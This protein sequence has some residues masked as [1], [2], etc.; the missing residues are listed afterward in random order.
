M[1]KTADLQLSGSKLEKRM[2]RK[3]SPCLSAALTWTPGR[4][5]RRR[6]RDTAPAWSSRAHWPP[7]SGPS[8]PS[9]ARRWAWPRR[10]SLCWGLLPPCPGCFPRAPPAAARESYIFS[11]Q[12]KK[13]SCSRT[14]TTPNPHRGKFKRQKKFVGAEGRDYSDLPR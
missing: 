11:A 13:K 12:K 8:S 6:R 2:N 14:S 4:K 1:L 10:C 9:P 5:L 7:G 3:Q